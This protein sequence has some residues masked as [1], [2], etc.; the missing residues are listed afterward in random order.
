MDTTID[1]ETIDQTNKFYQFGK[2]NNFYN[3]VSDFMAVSLPLSLAIFV[4]C[5]SFSW[6]LRKLNVVQPLQSFFKPFG[7]IITFWSSNFADNL[8]YLSFHCFLYLYKFVPYAHGQNSFPSSVLC[9]V[10]LF[11]SLLTVCFLGFAAWIFA[12]AIFEVEHFQSTNY[13]SYAFYS[14]ALAAKFFS[15]FLHAY[16]D[17]ERYRILG[18]LIVNCAVL[19]ALAYCLRAV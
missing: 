4:L 1:G 16:V 10:T 19:I 6:L 13:K 11:I 14:I 2:G 12:K 15:G 3:N 7:S 9:I 8:T 18:L 17:N 5:M